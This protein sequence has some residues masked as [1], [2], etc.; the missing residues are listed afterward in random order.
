MKTMMK[1]MIGLLLASASAQAKLGETPSEFEN[2]KPTYRQNGYNGDKVLMEWSGKNI[3]H[4]GTFDS[5][6]HAV[7]EAFT[8]IDHTP[9]TDKELGRFMAYPGV[10]WSRTEVGESGMQWSVGRANGTVVL[11]AA[12]GFTLNDPETGDGQDE[13]FCLQIWRVDYFNARLAEAKTQPPA[14]EEKNDCMVVA[15]EMLGRV[16][17]FAVWSVIVDQ[18]VP[19]AARTDRSMNRWNKTRQVKRKRTRS[20]PTPNVNQPN[21]MN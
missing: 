14:T 2:S 18:M 1:I 17:K 20:K 8:H 12:Y 6:W 13:P 15:T 3:V 5:S 11:I 9:L 7:F 10:T 21:F 19:P 16:K 4:A